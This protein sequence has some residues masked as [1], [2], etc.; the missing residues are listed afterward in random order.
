V[1]DETI[2]MSVS[3]V[4]CGDTSRSGLSECG[5]EMKGESKGESDASCGMGEEWIKM[6]H[7]TYVG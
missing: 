7:Y 4:D 1:D 3:L 5:L 6:T 2:D